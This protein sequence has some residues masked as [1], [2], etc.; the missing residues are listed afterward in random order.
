MKRLKD[1]QV[2]FLYKWVD[3]RA[4]FYIDLMRQNPNLQYWYNAKADAF[5]EIM[6]LL[7]CLAES[8]DDE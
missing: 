8:D 2:E 4:V 6:D 5:L 7:V 1:W 3:R